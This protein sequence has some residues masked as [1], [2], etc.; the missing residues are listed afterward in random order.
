MRP[1]F[2]QQLAI[3]IGNLIFAAGILGALYFLFRFN[4]STRE[5]VNLDLLNQRTN[6]IILSCTAII[7]GALFM[8]IP[9]I[10]AGRS[11]E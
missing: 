1:S 2:D 8:L 5:T 3:W 7:T 4:V 11:H 9:G 6:G 10:Q